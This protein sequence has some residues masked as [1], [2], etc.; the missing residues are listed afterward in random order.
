MLVDPSTRLACFSLSLVLAS[1]AACKADDQVPIDEGTS[2]GE[3]AG[4]TGD[5]G[6]DA[7]TWWRD[8]E[9]IVR[10]KCVTCHAAGNIAPFALETHA[11]F[12]AFAELAGDAI[13]SGVMPPW[14]ADPDC[15]DYTNSLALSLEQEETL[16]SYIA[17]DMPEGDPADAPPDEG[18]PT[19]ELVPDLV[20]DMPEAY[21][22]T[23]FPDDYRCFTIPWPEEYT[24]D[25]FV[26]GLEIYPG[27][28]AI[29]HH[30]IV[31]VATPGTEQTYLD[32]DAAEPGPGYTC[33]GGPGGQ[34]GPGAARWVGAWVPGIQPFFAPEGTGQR[35]QP[36]STLIMQVHYNSTAGEGLEDR[37]ALA[38]ELSSMVDRLGVTVPVTDVAWLA[39]DGSMLIPAGEANVTHELSAG[40]DHPIIALNKA[41]LGAAAE[42]PLEIWNVGMHMHLF[43]TSGQLELRSIGGGNE[44]CLLDIPR[45][46]FNW[47]MGHDLAAPAVLDVDEELH[48]R[49]TWDNSAEN[50]PIVDGEPISP[51]DRDWGDGTLDEMCLGVLYMT[52]AG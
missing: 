7:L 19:P 39:S 21:T 34:P 33:F 29:V 30:V 49:C 37:S 13:E 20:L 14:L 3:T 31:F 44:E 40:H 42:D 51:M 28:K 36:G 22:P 25:S 15:R 47:Q 8:V 11:E 48:M 45:W 4:E 2:T 24:E 52:T 6:T 38:L 35:I 18:T 32:L 10:E 17:S 16:L 9:P 1:L 43:G 12:V 46:D 41:V 23:K 5:G 50:Q 26:T 27:E